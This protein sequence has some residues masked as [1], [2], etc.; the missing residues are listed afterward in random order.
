MVY[1]AKACKD[2]LKILATELGLEIGETMRVID[3]KN[4]ILTSKDY[5]EQFTKTLLET[6]IETR[7]H[8]ERDEND[9]KRKQKGLILEL[10]RILWKR[11]GGSVTQSPLKSHKLPFIN[12]TY[13][14]IS[15]ILPHEGGVTSLLSPSYQM[16]NAD[17]TITRK[18]LI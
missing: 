17:L 2:D 14:E 15:C 9:Y 10:E 18:K 8:A 13:G 3:F 11:G 16:C 4:L 1:L 5:D 12:G 6:I 7:V